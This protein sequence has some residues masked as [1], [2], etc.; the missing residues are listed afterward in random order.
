MIG[1]VVSPDGAERGMSK[2]AGPSH[3]R[4]LSAVL[5]GVSNQ[6][7]RSTRYLGKAGVGSFLSTL[8]L[9]LDALSLD[10]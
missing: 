2:T 8:T 7:I 4:L 5:Y 9:L 3:G 1:V 10:S 6:E